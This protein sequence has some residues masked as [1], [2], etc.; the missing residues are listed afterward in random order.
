M[1]AGVVV[2]YG[3]SFRDE[4]FRDDW[5]TEERLAERFDQLWEDGEEWTEAGIELDLLK[6]SDDSSPVGFGVR[7]F[8]K[9]WDYD[10]WTL[11]SMVE[12]AAPS[13]EAKAA[14]DAVLDREKIPGERQVYVHTRWW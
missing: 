5:D 9:D 13:D 4:A 2:W 12:E 7:L 8:Y 3:V 11:A 14:V 10:P 1:D 6:P